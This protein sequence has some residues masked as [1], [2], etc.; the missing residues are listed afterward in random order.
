MRKSYAGVIPELECVIKGFTNLSFR[1][2]TLNLHQF[3]SFIGSRKEQVKASFIFVSNMRGEENLITK[4]LVLA[5]DVMRVG[6]KDQR[7]TVL[8]VKIEN[9]FVMLDLIRL[10]MCLDFK[11]KVLTEDTR[12]STNSPFIHLTYG[13]SDT[14]GSTYE[15]AWVES[16]KQLP[17]DSIF[18]I[19][20]S[21]I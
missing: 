19:P 2:N 21:L 18:V 7:I 11:V 8:M 13:A 17:V 15:V 12:Q 3:V 5:V 14:C 1:K 9:L 20:P 10:K 16:F 4:N 6:C